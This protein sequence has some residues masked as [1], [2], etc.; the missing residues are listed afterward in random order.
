M[1][2]DYLSPFEQFL[3]E[4]GFCPIC[5]SRSMRDKG[6]SEACNE[7]GARF[8]CSGGPTQRKTKPRA[9]E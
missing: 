3:F 5:I 7:C 1:D 4:A 2:S 6:S 8:S 9:M